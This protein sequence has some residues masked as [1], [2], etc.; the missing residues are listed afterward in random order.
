MTARQQTGSS[1][2]HTDAAKLVRHR[3]IGT[4]HMQSHNSNPSSAP[5][6]SKLQ[7]LSAL[8]TKHHKAV[9][10]VEIGIFF[11][12]ILLQLY[13]ADLLFSWR[14]WAIAMFGTLFGFSVMLRFGKPPSPQP[15]SD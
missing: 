7:T 9:H 5:A 10:T 1:G 2:V 8:M 4:A 15:V 11:L 3:S 14:G 6:G 12:M 13:G